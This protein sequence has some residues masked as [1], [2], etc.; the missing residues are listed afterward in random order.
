[1]P[2]PP[3]DAP[4][5]DHTCRECD[6]TDGIQTGTKHRTPVEIVRWYKCRDPRCR[7]RWKVVTKEEKIRT[8]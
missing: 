7:H 1:M 8:G 4:E 6:R 3:I 5:P 2:N